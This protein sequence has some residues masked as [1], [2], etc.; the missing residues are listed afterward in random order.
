[1]DFYNFGNMDKDDDLLSPGTIFPAR[2]Q[3]SEGP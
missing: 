1:M 3:Y 2:G